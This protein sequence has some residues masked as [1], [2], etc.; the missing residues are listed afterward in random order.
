VIVLPDLGVLGLLPLLVLLPILQP[1][2][3]RGVH[4]RA[5]GTVVSADTEGVR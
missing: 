3:H 2:L 5:A 4:D 1:P